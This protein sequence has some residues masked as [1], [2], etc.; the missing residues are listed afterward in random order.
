MWCIYNKLRQITIIIHNPKLVIT[1]SD[2]ALVSIAST[3]KK[4][5]M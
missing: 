2:I 1:F 4:N 3:N 5:R